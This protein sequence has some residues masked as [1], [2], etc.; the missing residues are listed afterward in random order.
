MSKQRC[1][2]MIAA[3]AMLGAGCND[4][5]SSS[6]GKSCGDK[7]CTDTQVCAE[8]IC[9]EVCGGETCKPGQVCAD[10]VCADVDLCENKTCPDGEVCKNGECEPNDDPCAKINCPDGQQCLSA[11]ARCVDDAC[12]ENGAEKACGDG[13][14]CIKGSCIDDGCVDKTC[15][16][17][18]QCIKGICEETA[19]LD[20]PC[21]NGQTCTGGKCVDNECLGMT[22]DGGKTCVKGDCVFDAC[23]GKDA[24]PD[25][26]ICVESGEC[27]FETAPA[28]VLDAMDDK[29]TDENGDTAVISIRLNNLPSADVTVTCEIS[30]VA[31][32]VADCSGILFNADNYADNQTITVTGLPDNIVDAD[33]NY[34][35][36]LKTVSS[37]AEFDGL[38]A[39]AELVNRNVDS[40]A[41][42][43]SATSLNTSESDTP[44]S[45]GLANFT[46]VLS[47]KPA[48]DVTVTLSSSNVGYG[49]IKDANENV[50]TVTFTPDNW[51][52]PQT[53]TIIGEDDGDVINLEPHTYQIEFGKTVSDDENFNG[54][55]T[56]PVSVFNIDNDKA[57]LIVSPASIE[58]E[59]GKDPAN[60]SVRLSF[61][62]L[63]EVT[64]TATV[65]ELDKTTV[66]TEAV[67]AQGEKLTFN[68]D[69]FSAE[70]VISIQGLHD[71]IIDGDKK[72]IVRL[73][74]TSE[75][76]SFNE[77]EDI[78]ID[79]VN[80]D[81]D[82]AAL[83]SSVETNKLSENGESADIGIS[84]SSIPAGDV[85]V[86]IHVSDSTELAISPKD[87]SAGEGGTVVLVF[88][89]D[90]WN[91]PQTFTA[92]GVDDHII[93]G[94][95]TSQIE[96][97]LDSRDNN[98]N[99]KT[100][101]IDMITVDDDIASLVIDA[102]GA[103]VMEN[104]GEILTFTVV[105]TAEPS[106]DVLVKLKSSDESELK[107]AENQEILFTS[108]DWNVPQM[109][110]LQ[111]VDDS[112]AD[113]TQAAVISLVSASEDVN[114]N[115]LKA[116]TPVYHILDNE[117]ASITM[118][119]ATTVLK[120]GEYTTTMTVSL[121]SE[122]I[123]DVV[124][125]LATTNE[126]T[127]AL[128]NTVLTFTPSN[129]NKSQ[130]VDI[131]D[132][133]PQSASAAVTVETISAVA[134]GSGAYSSVAIKPVDMTL[135]AFYGTQTF[136]YK[137]ETQSL[138]LLPGTYKLEVWGG[139]GS[140][141]CD[142]AGGPGGY[143]SGN[144]TLTSNQTLYIMT[145]GAGTGGWTQLPAACN[146]GGLPSDQT[147]VGGGGA[148]HIAST[149]RGD[150]KNYANNRDEIY[151]VA[152][153]GGGGGDY[154]NGG[155]GGGATGGNGSYYS[156]YTTHWGA[157]ATQTT[158]YA[159]GLGEPASGQSPAGGGGWYG[160]YRSTGGVYAGGGGGSGYTG[161][162]IGGSMQNGMNVGT[163]YAKVTLIK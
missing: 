109:V 141:D 63:N 103:D 18:F 67:V 115:E 39:V 131:T 65:L 74:I 153:G 119:P 30:N 68:A 71:N 59:E 98:F 5:S 96:F 138:S 147:G 88:T 77:L 50:L 32:A 155:S 64:V 49:N 100:D 38:T 21:P 43:V 161:G 14:M 9:V 148:T 7:T 90:N 4:D 46:V 83:V 101:K 132:K 86:I 3:L 79:G 122:P 26:K 120:P 124:V 72:Y 53:V 47:A 81:V 31:E 17:G 85:T 22:C 60:L 158:G 106:L 150:L 149:N 154:A 80:I 33:Q 78:Y 56:A 34:T 8:N 162:V 99:E 41:V 93:D 44:D 24:C 102:K 75:D 25:G 15:D 116:Q 117:T 91:V 45:E 66:S 42:V 145:G 108:A 20:V 37:D 152:G 54:L 136:S 73:N 134:A 52:V 10:G 19:C 112:S 92:T 127:A 23:V 69:N 118:T 13:Q 114:F 1:L 156:T 2:F 28:L 137:C 105:L 27:E 125:T 57:D 82:K 111:V 135:Y 16:A 61:A 151:I 163:G 121:T 40:A 159:F 11:I 97:V 76:S 144:I 51:N 6:Q 48:S 146:G 89:P 143:A 107:I 140:G 160:G 126:K 70:Q 12:I 58:T 29:D 139:R 84:L 110:K 36:T 157:G 104:S 87:G 130:T 142:G 95:I 94:D 62:P 129:W 128:S 113:G 55:D 123:S 133:D 35:V